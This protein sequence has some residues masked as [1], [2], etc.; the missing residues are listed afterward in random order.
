MEDVQS[1]SA[2]M[3]HT[4]ILKNCGNLW[5]TGWNCYGQLGDGTYYWKSTPVKVM[6]D[7]QSVSAGEYHTMIMVLSF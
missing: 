7:V 2:G 5:A 3:W 1:V 4:M 6:E